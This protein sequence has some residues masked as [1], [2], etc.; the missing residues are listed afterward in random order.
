MIALHQPRLARRSSSLQTSTRTLGFGYKLAG[1]QNQ[2]GL[3][4]AFQ[5]EM[6]IDESR[7]SV[8]IPFA[9]GMR[10]DGV[11]DLLE[12]TGINTERHRKNPIVLF[13]HGKEVKLPVA[14]AEDPVSKAYTVLIDPSSRT[15]KAIAYFY[16]GVSGIPGMEAS[17]QYQ[18]ALFCEQLFDLISRRFIRAGSI[19]YLITKAYPLEPDSQRGVPRGMHLLETLLLEVSAVVMPANQDTVRKMLDLHQVCGKPLCSYLVKSLTPYVQEKKVQLGYEN[20]QSLRLKYRKAGE[21]MKKKT[22]EMD[23]PKEEDKKPEG[24]G[25]P[26]QEEATEEMWGSQVARAIHKDHMALL[27]DYDEMLKPLENAKMR[28]YMEK[29]L[30][31]LEKV[32]SEIEELHGGEYPDYEPIAGQKD[33]D[34]V[35]A[36]S[37]EEELPSEDEA[38]EGMEHKQLKDKRLKD[39]RNKYK[40]KDD[41]KWRNCGRYSR[42]K[43]RGAKGVCPE[44]GQENCTCKDQV[45]DEEDQPG[46]EEHQEKP[47]KETDSAAPEG[48]EPGDEERE[49]MQEHEKGYLKGAHGFL[50]N[51]LGSKE[52]TD[53]HRMDAYHF[54]KTLL[55]IS[56]GEDTA[57]E[58]E[59]G[60]KDLPSSDISPEKARQILHDGEVNGKPLTDKQRRLFGAAASRGE[61][62]TPA[63]EGAGKEGWHKSNPEEYAASEAMEPQ[64]Q[65]GDWR[66]MCKGA[67]DFFLELSRAQTLEDAHREKAA[68]WHKQMEP[69]TQ[70]EMQAGSAGPEQTDAAMDAA[71]SL[72]EQF[73]KQG[74]WLQDVEMKLSRLSQYLTVTVN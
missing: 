34:S 13:D 9:D 57:A 1:D 7:M 26:K 6:D 16:G 74:N 59:V 39:L 20:N 38:V 36:D 72:K 52:W 46:D 33:E 40:T 18:H 45:V 69:Y 50:T 58:A 5:E 25:E 10:R 3:D 19:G 60:M 2:Y 44:C 68:M 62:S 11:G 42:C 17:E 4:V 55:G 67:S 31:N 64:H 27:Q 41:D 28:K 35:E 66:K 71:K 73:T 32:L 12:V 22:K 51:V 49:Q 56:G 14:L 53:Q 15:A 43:P 61:K 63:K 24:D 23:Q 30:V 54:H 8:V 29:L 65:M 70:D 37:Q 21:E 48:H 47:G